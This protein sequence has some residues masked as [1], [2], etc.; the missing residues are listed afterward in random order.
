MKLGVS[1]VNHVNKGGT[2]SFYIRD[3]K[4]RGREHQQ[5]MV[6]QETRGVS[7]T[8]ESSPQVLFNFPRCMLLL[9]YIFLQTICHCRSN[10][11][12]FSITFEFLKKFFSIYLILNNGWPRMG[13]K[14]FLSCWHK[15]ISNSV[16]FYRVLP[17]NRKTELIFTYN[18]NLDPCFVCN[19][20]KSH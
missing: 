3:E 6:V 10:D 13:H 8:R 12:L 19:T 1:Y 9:K 5:N 14:S 17:S 18:K 15:L 20:I 4:R 7:F 2:L 16:I 11:F